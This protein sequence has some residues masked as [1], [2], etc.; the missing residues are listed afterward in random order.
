MGLGTELRATRRGW[1]GDPAVG[2]DSGRFSLGSC[3]LLSPPSGGCGHLWSQCGPS[4]A[5]QGSGS[6]DRSVCGHRDVGT[7]WV[8]GESFCP[9]PPDTGLTLNLPDTLKALSPFLS[10]PSPKPVTPA[11]SLGSCRTENSL[12]LLLVPFVSLSSSCASAP[13]EQPRVRSGSQ[14]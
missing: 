8:T 12:L 3:A 9:Q 11:G 7:A 1:P 2:G 14:A 13:E 4:S 10:V 6:W 5:L